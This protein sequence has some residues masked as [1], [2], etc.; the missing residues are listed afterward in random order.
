MRA[1]GQKVLFNAGNLIAGVILA[2]SI[3]VPTEALADDGTP[4]NPVG[5]CGAYIDYY[6]DYKFACEDHDELYPPRDP[7]FWTMRDDEFSRVEVYKQ[8]QFGWVIECSPWMD[9][10]RCCWAFGGFP[11]RPASSCTP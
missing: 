4:P 7:C 2:I 9:T 8:Y 6:L 11:A 3:L 10:G 1:S 5:P